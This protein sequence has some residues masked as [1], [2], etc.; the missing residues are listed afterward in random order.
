M[1][2]KK[3]V[4]GTFAGGVA[5]F[6]IG[7]AIYGVALEGFFTEHIA[8]CAGKPM[9]EMNWGALILGNV[10]SGALLTYIFLKWANVSS[11]GA[12]ATAGATIGF[13]IALSMNM[14]RFATSNMIDLT[15]A[16]GDTGAYTVLAAI[17][18]GII[19]AVLGMGSKK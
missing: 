15:G 2:T 12:G 17:S 5:F 8:S 14:V 7:Y 6:F 11:F 18:G 16:L 3:F 19:G 9:E 1:D 13:F 4:M 10:S